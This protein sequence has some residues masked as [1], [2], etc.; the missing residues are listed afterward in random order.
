MAG[1]AIAGLGLTGPGQDLLR[2]AQ[3]LWP[4]FAV[5]RDGQQFAAP[6]A[7]AEALGVGLAAAWLAR[8]PVP[9][10]AA[11]PAC[12][13]GPHPGGATTDRHTISI[14]H[15]GDTNQVVGGTNQMLVRAGLRD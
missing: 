14:G 2:A 4:G 11:R 6:L 7:L 15:H 9:Q 3:A 5:L 13:P 10:R 12:Q 8:R 1:L